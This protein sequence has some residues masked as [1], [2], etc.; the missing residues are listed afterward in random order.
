MKNLAIYLL[1]V[2][3]ILTTGCQN[4]K[5][6]LSEAEKNQI[7]QEIEKLSLA[8]F[9][10]WNKR[11]Y[12]SYLNYYLNSDEFTFAANGF[13]VRSWQAFSDTVKAHT[14]LYNRAEAKTI[15]RYIDIIDRDIVILTQTFDWDATLISGEDEKMMGT[16]TTVYVKREGEWKITNTSES[17][18]GQF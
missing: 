11:D 1:A 18:P 10:S 13:V 14:A 12:D 7:R 9:D 17:F 3:L 16:Y 4:N 15:K 2:V 6:L 8:L 5:S